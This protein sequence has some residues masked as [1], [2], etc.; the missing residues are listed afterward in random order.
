MIKRFI[1]VLLTFTMVVL[2]LS[3]CDQKNKTVKIGVSFGVGPATRWEMEKSYM[4][5]RAAEIGA[6]IE[7][8]LNRT[9]EPKTQQEDCYEMI[10]S[11]I[12][13]LI[14]TPRDVTKVSDILEYAKKK[15]VPVISYAR[16]VLGQK[17][18]LFVGYDSGRI[19]QKMG[20]YISEIAFEGNYI[21]LR[22]DEN[23][24]NAQLLYEGAMRYIDPIKT[25]VNVILDAPVPNWSPD[26][27]KILV[28]EAIKKADGK[29]NAILAPNDKIAAVCADVIKEL[30]VENDVI[31]TGMDAEID[32]VKRIVEGTQTITVY[33]DLKELASTAVNEAYHIAKGEKVN[34]NAEFDNQSGAAIDANL[35]TG[36]VVDKGNIDR[37]LIDSG[38]FT[39]EQIYN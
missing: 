12:D 28:S 23:D 29:I 38:Y 13:V 18:D 24:N 35:I 25:K 15:N 22:G 21:I 1:Y 7:V 9:D 8:R 14:L 33:M 16:I 30:G 20:Q 5:A 34:I 17:V 11:G 39:K 6:E 4:E 36:Q 37:V 32:A 3:G 10:D 26:A 19:G 2:S 27:A 31:I